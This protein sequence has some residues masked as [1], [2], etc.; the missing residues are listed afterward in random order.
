METRALLSQLQ[1]SGFMLSAT[2][3]GLAVEPASRLTAETRE[4]IRAHRDALLEL[5]RGRSEPSNAEIQEHL[6]RLLPGEDHVDFPEALKI[7]LRDPA[8]ALECL[9]SSVGPGERFA[10]EARQ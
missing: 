5:L 2:S 3:G 1:G 9:R 10:S 8:A 6:T 7:A 4:L